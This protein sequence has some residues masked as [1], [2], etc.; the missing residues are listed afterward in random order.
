LQVGV[1]GAGSI[2]GGASATSSSFTT[3]T[4][5]GVN[6]QNLVVGGQKVI[7]GA[8]V[9]AGSGTIGGNVVIGSSLSSAGALRPGDLAGSSSGVLR[10][11]GSLVVNDGSQIQFNLTNTLANDAGFS[12]GS[13]NAKT[14]VDSIYSG[15]TGATYTQYWKSASGSYSA[16]QVSGSLTLGSAGVGSNEPTLLVTDNSGSYNAGDV[17][18]LLD[19]A[20]VGTANSIAGGGNFNLANDLVLPNL[21]SRNL[22][23]DIS[24]FTTYGVLAVVSVAPAPEPGR[25]LLLLMGSMALVM[26]RRRA[27]A[28]SVR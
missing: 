4:T 6:S 2:V 28:V 20:S 24:A 27:S 23:W 3:T 12:S 26:R 15:G 16:I 7:T 5:S 19:W 22:A 9:I 18:K 25:V 11:G 8:P 13:V 14:Y 1:G 21:S 10:I 17:F